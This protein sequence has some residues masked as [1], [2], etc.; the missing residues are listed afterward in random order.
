MNAA[1]WLLAAKLIGAAALLAAGAAGV[2]GCQEHYRSQGRDEVQARW[3]DERRENAR[4][5]AAARAAHERTQRAKEQ[6]MARAAEENARVQMQR[7]QAVAHGAAGVQRSADGLRDA[8]AQHDAASR[9]RG[10]AGTCPA[11]S[12]E[13]DEAATARA[14]LG[15]CAGEYRELA[16]DAAS[17]A[18]Q[19]RGLQDHIVAVQP[20]AAPLLAQQQVQP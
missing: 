20:E 9:S 2:R 6:T 10:A 7:E 13:A 8:I 17:L 19:V 1:A 5:A 12:A 14:L 11:A 4:I 18:V 3:D 16:Q 15:A